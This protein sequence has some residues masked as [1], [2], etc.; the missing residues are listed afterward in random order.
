MSPQQLKQFVFIFIVCIFL[1]NFVQASNSDVCPRPAVGS[2]VSEPVDLRS[3]NG[4]LKIELEYRSSIDAQGRTRFCFLTKDGNQ[5]PNLRLRPG[6]ELVL[7]LK[8]NLSPSPSTAP[9]AGHAMAHGCTS[10][11]MDATSTNLH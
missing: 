2:T 10:G 8:N 4:L 3:S 7:T 9:M 5:A 6:D 11:P 1:P